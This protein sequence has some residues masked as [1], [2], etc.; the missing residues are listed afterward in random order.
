MRSLL[1]DQG[2]LAQGGVSRDG[3]KEIGSRDIQEG[4]AIVWILCV[5]LEWEV[6]I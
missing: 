6:K 4:L 1:E 5:C 2:G 3:E